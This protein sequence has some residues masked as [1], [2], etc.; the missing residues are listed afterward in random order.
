[1]K[2]ALKHAWSSCGLKLRLEHVEYRIVV[3]R[4]KVLMNKML[5]WVVWFSKLKRRI[6]VLIFSVM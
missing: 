3:E 6:I 2:T 5:G 1:M 4:Y